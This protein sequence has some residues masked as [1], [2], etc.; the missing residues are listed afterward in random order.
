MT[1]WRV[2]SDISIGRTHVPNV[3]DYTIGFIG[4]N[5]KFEGILQW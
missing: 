2:D 1:Y 4:E 5:H 3:S